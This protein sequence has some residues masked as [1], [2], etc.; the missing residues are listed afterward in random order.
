MIIER[1]V[2]N[3]RVQRPSES[4]DDFITDLHTLAQTLNYGTM[5]DELIRDRIVVG[6][7]DKKLSQK[8]QLIPNLTLP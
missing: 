4:V 7:T 5:K 1:A 6:I 8:L 2:F 3:S